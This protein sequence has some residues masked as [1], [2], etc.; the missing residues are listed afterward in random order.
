MNLLLSNN[1]NTTTLLTVLGIVAVIAVVFAV[2]IIIISK[3][4]AVK[5]DEKAEAI[6]SH[7]SGANCG[8]CGFAGCADYA[9]ALSEGRADLSA[10]GPT[11][12]EGKAEIA[13]ILGV[14]F[15]GEEAKY[16]VVHCAGGKHSKDM[17]KYFG[18]GGCIAESAFGGGKKQCKSGCMGSGSCVDACPYHAIEVKD[19]VAIA[20]KALCEACGLCVKTCPKK[21]IELIPKSSKV[22]VACSSHC[23]GKEVIGTCEKGCIACG[24][25]VKNCPSGAITMVDNVPVIDYSKCTGCKVCA[26]KCP[27]KCILEI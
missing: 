12:N 13:K 1:I 17:F 9:K 26:I 4:C 10:C 3:V 6:A 24:I 19:G 14:P 21:L 15:A 25:C 8:G 16:V 5:V 7:L 22:Y 18:N 20:D 23:K 27:R 2:L 11:S